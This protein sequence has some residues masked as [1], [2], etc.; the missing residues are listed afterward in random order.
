MIR[1]FEWLHMWKCPSLG[2][3]RLG[4]KARPVEASIKLTDGHHRLLERSRLMRRVFSLNEDCLGSHW[5]GSE[6]TALRAS[7]G[8]PKA[9]GS[10]HN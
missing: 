8:A 7:G 6:R 10:T 1:D 3:H 9:S 2:L 5:L 4:L